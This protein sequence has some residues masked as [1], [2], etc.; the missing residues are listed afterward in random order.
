VAAEAFAMKR[1]H[2]IAASVL[3]LAIFLALDAVWLS[4]MVD[5]LYRPALGALLAPSPAWWPALLF[6][7]LYAL[8]ITGFAVAPAYERASWRVAALRGAALG[9]IAYASYDLS[10]QA[11]LRGWSWSV[12][13]ADLAWGTVATALT[14]AVTTRLLLARRR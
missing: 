12:T 1:G 9:L 7:L 3:A 6:Y 13:L 5:R 2:W 4:L 10:N 8:G 14:A 11:T